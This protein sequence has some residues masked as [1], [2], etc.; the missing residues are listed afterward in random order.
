MYL[1][2][3][4]FLFLLPPETAHHLVMRFVSLAPVRFLLNFFFNTKH[5]SLQR[6]FFGLHFKNPV[7]LAAGFDKDGNYIKSLQS[8]GFGFIEL[9]TVTPFPQSGNPKPRLFRLIK[10]KALINRMGFNNEGVDFLV[11]KLSML[12]KEGLI[13]GGNIGKNKNTPN[14]KAYLDYEICFKKLF[15]WVD[16]FAVNVSSPNTP[17]L[18]DLQEKEPLIKILEHLMTINSSK[19]IPKPIFLKIAPDLTFSQLDDILE[20]VKL[21]G[22]HGIIA[23]N[24]TIRRD[25]LSISRNKLEEIG[26][27]GLSGKPLN[28]RSNEVIQYLTDKS[29]GQLFIIGVGGIS[30]EVDALNKLRA[31]ASLVQIYSGLIY[32]GPSLVSKINKTLV[33]SYIS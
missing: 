15:D 28:D 7:G 23:T 8:I 33:K 17:G 27:G 19:S 16:Y 22:I 32:E 2:L 4:R 31:G 20:I 25:G 1:L 9:G 24:T 10:D 14:D 11:K 3:K 5:P 26:S 12:D 30:T 13:I 6:E 18:R 29:Q 21:T